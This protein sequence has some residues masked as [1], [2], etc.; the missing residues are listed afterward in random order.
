M[1]RLKLIFTFMRASFQNESAYRLNFFLNFLSAL[2]ALAGGVGGIYILYVNNE[3]LNGWTMP[4]TLAVLG[5][6]MLVQAVKGVV[7]GPSLNKLGGMDGEIERG[8]FDYT[9]LKPISTQYYISV[10]EWSLWSILHIAVAVGVIGFSIN[11]MNQGIHAA[12][13]VVFL[14]ALLIS[15]GILYSMMLIVSSLAFWYRG[16]YVLWIMEDILQAGR[17]PVGIY[18]RSLRLLLTWVLPVGFIVTVPAEA[19]VQRTQPLTLAA[20]AVL[21]TVLFVCATI[22]FNRSLHKYSGASS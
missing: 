22:F 19:L 4:E 16:T 14:L 2:L 6:Y 20:G 11:G 8:T 18:P 12:T 21:M 13:A 3:A 5:V 10:R 15:L 17:Y 7:I 9:L 1:S